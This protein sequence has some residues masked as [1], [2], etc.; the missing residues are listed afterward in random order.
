V[1]GIMPEPSLICGVDHIYLT[2]S[3]MARSE[4]YYDRVCAA[5]GFRKGTKPIAGE[6]HA[7]YFLPSLQITLRPAHHHQPHDPYAAGLHHLC[8]QAPDRAAVDRAFA[9]LQ[10]LGAAPSTPRFHTDAGPDYYATF[11]EDP[12]GIRLE[13]VARTAARAALSQRWSEFRAFLNPL[14]GLEGRQT[15]GAGSRPASRPQPH[16][17]RRQI[18]SIIHRPLRPRRGTRPETTTDGQ[19]STRVGATL[20]S[21]VSGEE[22][23]VQLTRCED[24]GVP[25]L[26]R[27]SRT[28]RRVWSCV[29]LR[30]YGV[31][32][33]PGARA[34]AYGA[35]ATPLLELR[36]P[37]RRSLG[38][39]SGK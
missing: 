15:S 25:Q 13:I 36:V 8:L 37:S 23:A 10:G 18:R 24:S 5:L 12:D 29:R 4:A 2:V 7:H 21:R 16:S 33:R 17:D 32:H 6:R 26:S 19:V 14:A 30:A 27:T 20:P 11:F 35:V 31:P 39:A 38:S 22:N 34:S 3:D 9:I 1:H 28:A